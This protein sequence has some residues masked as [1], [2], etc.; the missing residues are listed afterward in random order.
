MATSKILTQTSAPVHPQGTRFQ[1]A[2]CVDADPRC[3][4]RSIRQD[5]AGLSSPIARGAT[6]KVATFKP[7]QSRE[8]SAI[9]QTNVSCFR[10]WGVS[11]ILRLS[12]QWKVHPRLSAKLTSPD[13]VSNP[14]CTSAT[15]SHSRGSDPTDGA[16]QGVTYS[17]SILLPV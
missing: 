8:G 12:A 3:L 9:G 16:G 2:C 10:W 4:R 11:P 17:C 14:P 15:P 7:E 13:A 1:A 6:V 5:H